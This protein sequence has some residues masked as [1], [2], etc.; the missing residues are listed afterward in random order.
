MY[1][2]IDSGEMNGLRLCRMYWIPFLAMIRCT[3]RTEVLSTWA[4][5][6]MS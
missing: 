5:V 2:S 4:A 1:S 6:P 3:E